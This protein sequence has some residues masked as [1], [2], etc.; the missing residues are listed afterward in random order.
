MGDGQ[1]SWIAAAPAID[2]LNRRSCCGAARVDDAAAAG[3]A[4]ADAA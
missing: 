1:R 3:A 2:V 4:T